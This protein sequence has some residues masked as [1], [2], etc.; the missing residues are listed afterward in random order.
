MIVCHC[1]VVS[2]GQ[3]REAIDAGAHDHSSVAAMCGAGRDCLG[4]APTVAELL[5][6]AALAL[7]EPRS[8]RRRQAERRRPL[9]AAQSA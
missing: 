9:V 4:C 2:D 5:E 1:S 8:L 3:I 7:R 6:D